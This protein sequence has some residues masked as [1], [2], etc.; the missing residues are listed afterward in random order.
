MSSENGTTDG[1]PLQVKDSDDE[2]STH[3]RRKRT[4]EDLREQAISTRM[5]VAGRLADNHIS[6]RQARQNYRGAVSQ[7]LHE[8]F[9]IIDADGVE[10][11]EGYQEDVPLGTVT[12][13]PPQDV[14]DFARDNPDKLLPD[15]SIPRPVTHNVAGLRSVTQLPS[16]LSQVFVVNY[17]QG[18]DIK[19]KRGT[20]K[21]DLSMSVLDTAMEQATK[22]LN[23]VGVGVEL[24]EGEQQTKITD[25]MIYKIDKWRQQNIN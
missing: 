9:T 17:R 1:R 5:E 14:V 21:T 3:K 6:E 8:V 2:F 23:E 13:E 7:F 15:E 12:F 20:A 25:Q 16:P 10:L 18:G 22:A 11:S 24:D 4:L 19:A